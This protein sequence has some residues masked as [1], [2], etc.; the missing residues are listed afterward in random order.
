MKKIL[1]ILK[2]PR[3]NTRDLSLIIFITLALS[4]VF[5]LINPNF[6]D[7]YNLIS[8]G[9]NLAPYA[10]LALGVLMPISMGGTDLSIGAVCIGAAVVAGKLYS[11]GMPLWACIPVMIIFGGLIGFV[12]TTLLWIVGLF[13]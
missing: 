6:I 7:K 10:L 4:Y 1:E 9:Q 5:A 12:I 13:N 11:L 2:S 8:I 3:R